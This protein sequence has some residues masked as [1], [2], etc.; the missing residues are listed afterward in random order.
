MEIFCKVSDLKSF[1]KAARAVHLSQPT[2]SGHIQSL[3]AFLGVKLFDRLGR[4]V[5]MTKAGR[6]LYD[7]AK[8]ILEVRAEAMGAMEDYLGV[9]KG[10][11]LVGASTI[12]GGYLLP[13]V[14]GQFREK[15]PEATI[16]VAIKDTL[17]VAEGV[18]NGEFELGVIGARLHDDR[19]EYGNFTEDELILAVP[20]SHPWANRKRIGP[21]RL[22]EGSFIR[23]ELGSGTRTVAEEKL[24]EAGIE[25]EKLKV[26]AEM[27]G[28][29]AVRNALRAGLGAA[30]ISRVAV[31]EDLRSGALV[32]VAIEGVELRRDFYVVSHRSRSFT[33]LCRAFKDFLLQW[34][35]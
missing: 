27:G 29:E 2:A 6:V 31:E 14:V 32:E 20:P 24:K 35:S 4:E 26:V 3:E 23:R 21:E 17:Q 7:Y 12:P 15:Y 25:A 13:R 28:T 18:L 10:S 34:G 11:L 22:L 19:L 16:S 9:I 5:S 8:R 30:I 33:P 1:S